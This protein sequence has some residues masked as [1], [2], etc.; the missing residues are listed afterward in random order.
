MDIV[1]GSYPRNMR[2]IG[3][4]G[5]FTNKADHGASARRWEELAEIL[6]KTQRGK[7]SEAVRDSATVVKG[8]IT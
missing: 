2:A 1:L 3:M 6:G 7:R 4:A 5:P 8:A